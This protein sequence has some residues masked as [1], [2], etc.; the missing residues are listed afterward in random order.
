VNRL[1][2]RLGRP[3]MAHDWEGG[4]PP[5]RGRAVVLLVWLAFIVAPLLDAIFRP[6]HGLTHGLVI[7]AALTFSALY[8]W[9]VLTWF[10]PGTRRTAAILSIAMLLLAVGLTALDRTSWGYLFSYTAACTAL[11][12][13]RGWSFPA[14]FGNAALAV[15]VS[16]AAGASAG[17]SFGFAISAVGVGLLL[18]LM[19]DLRMR[20]AE[21]CAARAELAHVAVAEERERFAR[22]L[23]DL[24]GHTLSVIA[25]KAELAGRLLPDRAAEAAAEVRDVERVARTALGEVRQAV[26]GYRQPTLAGELE[27]ARVALSA[28]GIAAEFEGAEVALEPEV[29]AVLAWA[30]R[31][32]ATNVIR[33]SRAG[34]CRIRVSSGLVDAAVEVVDDGIG[35]QPTNGNGGDL[36]NGLTGLRER[37]K[38]RRGRIE[39]GRAPGG[40]FR[41]AVSVPISVAAS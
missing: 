35:A 16:A 27:G 33:H 10:D 15:V 3:G 18:S 26:S 32:G 4:A 13:P 19:R 40:G 37:A 22:D 1:L 25:I 5:A 23:H 9:L 20:N 36:G 29:E 28:A 39:A 38:R 34:R 14:A 2:R 7:A 17:S 30:V 11:T 41:L 12:A 8:V 6:E 24:L 31:E 21:L